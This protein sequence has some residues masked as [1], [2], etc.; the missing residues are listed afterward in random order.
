VVFVGAIIPR[1]AANASHKIKMKNT[2]ATNE[3]IEPI[4]DRTFHLV[5]VSG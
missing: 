5:Y 2:R 1:W 4:L 3:I